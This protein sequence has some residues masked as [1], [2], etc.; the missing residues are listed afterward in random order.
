M[1]GAHLYHPAIVGPYLYVG[2]L[3]DWV[4]A[5]YAVF[6][7]CSNDPQSIIDSIR[8][9]P[10]RS[11]DDKTVLEMIAA[12]RTDDVVRYMALLSAGYVG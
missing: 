7:R 2:R 4:H 10:I 5:L 3:R 8:N 1:L 11:F 9:V 12:G 6:V